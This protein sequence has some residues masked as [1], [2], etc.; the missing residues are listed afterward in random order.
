MD[1]KVPD[2]ELFERLRQQHE[3]IEERLARTAAR[4]GSVL[5]RL[6]AALALNVDGEAE[7]GPDASRAALAASDPAASGATPA[8]EST[9][10]V[11]VVLELGQETSRPAVSLARAGSDA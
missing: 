10:A 4:I 5:D 2:T 9:G 3:A 7:T 6:A 1:A 8:P 11:P